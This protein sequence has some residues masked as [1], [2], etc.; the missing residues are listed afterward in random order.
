MTF[1]S[2]T[3]LLPVLLVAGCVGINPVYDGPPPD[4][5]D[6]VG[7]T[8]E[9]VDAETGT[10]GEKGE[11]SASLDTSTTSSTSGTGTADETDG[12]AD[13]T[14]GTSGS[15]ETEICLSMG[16]D[17]CQTGD[18]IECVDLEEDVRH[19]GS[20]FNDCGSAEVATCKQGTCSC[21]GSPWWAL[22]LGQ[23]THVRDDPEAC[24]QSCTDCIAT[25]GEGSTCDM[26]SCQ[27]PPGGSRGDDDD[28]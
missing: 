1:R 3:A 18:Q 20:C 17:V 28:G 9:P 27:E 21:G 6:D 23:C 12:R 24:G 15:S 14:T 4:A 22:C 19:C 16:L 13:D 7:A 10:T 26:G 25:H 11:T 2:S 8:S 5:D